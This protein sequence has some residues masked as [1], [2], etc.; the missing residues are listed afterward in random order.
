MAFQVIGST[1][2]SCISSLT[3]KVLCASTIHSRITY[4]IFI[5]GQ[6]LS[7][8]WKWKLLMSNSL[9]PH[10]LYGPWH[11]PGQNTG[12]DSLSLQGILPTQ[13]SNPGLQHCRQILYQLSHQWSQRILMWV[14]Y[15]F[16][17]GSSQPRNWTGVSCIAGGF[18]TSWA[19]MKL[20]IGIHILKLS[21]DTSRRQIEHVISIRTAVKKEIRDSYYRQDS[22][23]SGAVERMVVLKYILSKQHQTALVQQFPIF[24][25]HLN[26]PIIASFIL[27]YFSSVSGL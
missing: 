16:S 25:S 26:F 14:A 7:Q 18:F 22:G 12:M 10:G 2:N 13:G 19:T 8:A 27:F 5:I 15:P 17:R 21:R 11:S 24:P 1:S 9:R 3:D 20:G 6:A 23:V 4:W